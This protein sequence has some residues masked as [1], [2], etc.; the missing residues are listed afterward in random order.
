MRL[1]LATY[2]GGIGRSVGII[3]A[4]FTTIGGEELHEILV[5][6]EKFLHNFCVY[7]G[8]W[9]V[10]DIQEGRCFPY[11]PDVEILWRGRPR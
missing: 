4:A 10:L 5:I 8:K 3:F 7:C 9:V 2:S 11:Y 6:G 1:S